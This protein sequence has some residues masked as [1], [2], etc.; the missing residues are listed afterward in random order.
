MRS[1]TTHDGTSRR[2]DRTEPVRSTVVIP[3]YNESENLP[4]LVRRLMELDV[5]ELRVLVVD[6]ASPDGT[7]SVADA[8]ADRYPGRVSVLHRDAKQ[9]LGTA[10]V[11]GFRWALGNGAEYVLQMDADFS[12]STD[13]IPVLLR[14]V[15]DCDLVIG[16]R[17]VAGGGVYRDR[18]LGRNLISW[19]AN[20][21]FT[22]LVIGA[23]I[24]DATSGFRCWRRGA[25]EKIGLGTVRSKGYVFQVEMCRAARRR[26]LRIRETPIFF[27]DRRHGKSKMSLR[28]QVEATVWF[29]RMLLRMLR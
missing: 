6:D 27:E 23:P 7:G 29:F 13:Y 4:E 24:R 1:T 28:I 11:E 22:R 20:T 21:I 10:Y 9:G 26:G 15:A 16:S 17:Y 14:A 5:G 8:L 3:T 12:H 25:L 19:C 18:S 2:P